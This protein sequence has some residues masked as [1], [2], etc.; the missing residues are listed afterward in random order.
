MFLNKMFH[1]RKLKNL[2]CYFKIRSTCCIERR[3]SCWYL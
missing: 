3:K 1:K 2:K